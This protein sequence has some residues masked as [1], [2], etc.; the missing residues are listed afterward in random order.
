MKI[1]LKWEPDPET[2]CW[3]VTSHRPNRLGYVHY[4]RNGVVTLAHRYVYEMCVGAIPEGM[5]LCHRCD[6][7]QCVNPQHMF[8]GSHKDNMQD[9]RNKGRHQHGE[10]SRLAKLTEDQV[11][12]IVA[13]GVKGSPRYPGNVIELAAEFGVS[14]TTIYAILDGRSWRHLGLVDNKKYQYKKKWGKLFESEN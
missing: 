14:A 4:R 7:P 6:N 8:L 5:C 3:I 10:A 11:R 2:G 13:R 9:M 1:D 12:D